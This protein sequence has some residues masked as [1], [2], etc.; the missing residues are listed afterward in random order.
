MSSFN[1]RLEWLE[2]QMA[3][4]PSPARLKKLREEAESLFMER[5]NRLRAEGHP[6]VEMIMDGGSPYLVFVFTDD[7]VFKGFL[8]RCRLSLPQDEAYVTVWY[9]SRARTTI[10]V[11]VYNSDLG[12]KRERTYAPQ[13]VQFFSVSFEDHWGRREN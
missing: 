7:E 1:L 2:E 5:A 11:G 10:E 3:S 4:Y 9:S 13:G 8:E 6:I 12:F